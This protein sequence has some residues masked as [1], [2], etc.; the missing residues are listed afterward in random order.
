[1]LSACQAD[2]L[3]AGHFH[4][5]H[6]QTRSDRH[7]GAHEAADFKALVVQAGT[8]TSTRGRGEQNSFNVIRVEAAQIEIER[9][10][11]Q[12]ADSRFEIAGREHFE[13]TRAGWL[14]REAPLPAS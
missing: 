7:D 5:S 8:A 14:R 1:M 12:V 2:I 13:R 10:S 6:A 9:V 4:R 3:L 11:W